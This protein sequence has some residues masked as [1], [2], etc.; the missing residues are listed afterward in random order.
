MKNKIPNEAFTHKGTSVIVIIE[1]FL[2]R[3]TT[4]ID[5]KLSYDNF[6][7]TR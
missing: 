3:N 2:Q 6:L 7:A 5:F 4:V 1:K